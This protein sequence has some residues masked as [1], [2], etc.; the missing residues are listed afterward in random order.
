M[1]C[2][3]SLDRL[4]LRNPDG[5]PWEVHS[6]RAGT[7]F[8]FED[9]SGITAVLDQISISRSRTRHGDKEV[10]T[11]FGV[12]MVASLMESTHS[13]WIARS[14]LDGKLG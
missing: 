6:Y 10:D 13:G 12:S 11:V 8:D 1:S 3:R 4:G 5:I 9:D 14:G 7:Y 2:N